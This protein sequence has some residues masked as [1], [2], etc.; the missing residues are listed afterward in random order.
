MMC[1]GHNTTP[2]VVLEDSADAL[3]QWYTGQVFKD[4]VN[5][6][7][8]DRGINIVYVNNDFFNVSTLL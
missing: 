7:V 1:T 5:M 6:L 8:M 4:H 3:S 2:G